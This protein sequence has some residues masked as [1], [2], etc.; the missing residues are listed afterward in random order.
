MLSILFLF[1]LDDLTDAQIFMV[2]ALYFK[3]TWLSPFNRSETRRDIFY[4]EKQ[5]KLGEVDMMYQMSFF[6]YSRIE[7]IGGYAIE[8]PYGK[9]RTYIVLKKI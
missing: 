3:G 7:W 6:P 1:F 2:S 9:V 8:L 5:N 4:D